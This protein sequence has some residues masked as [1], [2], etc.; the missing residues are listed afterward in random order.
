MDGYFLSI[1]GRPFPNL[2]LN[3][4]LNYHASTSPPGRGLG[5]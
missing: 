3:L 1:F 2:T 4:P 5:V